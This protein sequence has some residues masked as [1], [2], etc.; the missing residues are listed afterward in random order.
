MY[1]VFAEKYAVFSAS[2]MKARNIAA[3]SCCSGLR[4]DGIARPVPPVGT[5]EPEG[6]SGRKAVPISKSAA[7]SRPLSEPVDPTK[8]P[9]IPAAKFACVSVPTPATFESLN[10]PRTNSPAASA[11]GVSRVTVHSSEYAAP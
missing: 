10:S 4:E 1:P 8:E 2:V 11:S 3:A 5:P 6:P 9:K 7:S